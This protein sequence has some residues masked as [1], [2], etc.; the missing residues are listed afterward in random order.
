M[1]FLFRPLAIPEVILVEPRRSGDARGFFMETYKRSEFAVNGIAEDF[2]QD[3]YSRSACGVLR[4]L[5]YQKQ[6]LAQ[7]KLVMVMQGAV[8]DVAVDIRPVSPTFARWVGVRLSADEPRLLYV[9]PGFAHGFCVLSEMADFTYKVTREYSQA[10]ERGIVWNDPDIAVEWPVTE[11][12]LST[13]DQA[14]PALRHADL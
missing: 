6:P 10:H 7:G 5:H 9:P 14:L 8:F 13:R 1:P 3:N 12:T 4:G 2:V 11:P